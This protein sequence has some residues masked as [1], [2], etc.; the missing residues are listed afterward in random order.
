MRRT[1]TAG[2][3]DGHAHSIRDSAGQ[4]DVV[5]IARSVTID[6]RQK[7]LPCT[8][9]LALARPLNGVE[10]GRSASAVGDHTPRSI[11]HS[12]VDAGDDALSTEHRRRLAEHFGISY[13]GRVD[14]YLVRARA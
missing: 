2:R 12:G 8:E 9:P 1:S 6:A 14:S 13:G 4:V 7:D 3:N 11:D 10:S 5:S